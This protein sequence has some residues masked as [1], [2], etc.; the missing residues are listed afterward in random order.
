MLNSFAF[1]LRFLLGISE[2]PVDE[3]SVYL[4]VHTWRGLIFHISMCMHN[5]IIIIIIIKLLYIIIYSTYTID[6]I[7]GH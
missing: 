4:V 5:I 6:T 3:Y 1:T 2:L 7:P